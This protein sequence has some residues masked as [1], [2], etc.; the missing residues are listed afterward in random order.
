MDANAPTS[1][2]VVGVA[3]ARVLRPQGLAGLR[4]AVAECVQA[5]LS[6]APLGGGTV[7][8]VGFPP[9]RL[10]AAISMH[11]V[12]GVLEHNP[13][14]FTVSVACGT[15]L[16][17]LEA[18]LLAHGQMLPLDAPFPERAT[19]GGTLAVG[20]IGHRAGRYGTL[21]DLCIGLKAIL[22]TGEEVKSGG[23]V[24]KNVTGYDLTKLHIGALG[25]LGVIATANFRL[26][27][28]PPRQV[29]MVCRFAGRT[30]A[31]EAALEL[32]RSVARFSALAVTTPGVYG[33]P[34]E[35][36][37]AVMVLWEG[38]PR[39]ADR[40]VDMVAAT[41]SRLQGQCEQLEGGASQRLWGSVRDWPLE[42]PSASPWAAVRVRFRPS[43]AEIVLDRLSRTAAE[44]GLQLDGVAHVLAGTAYMKVRWVGQPGEQA[45]RSVVGLLTS[46]ARAGLRMLVLDWAPRSMGP[47]PVWGQDPPGLELMRRIKT[48]FDPKGLIN[49]GRFVGRL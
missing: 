32:A 34:S 33:G 31:F 14:D 6:F 17:E 40:A 48:S 21:R 35:E 26:L 43:E 8:A 7:L 45:E 4:E 47:V 10:D 25:T 39:A 23:M 15:T 11:E 22:G 9:E 16:S 38:S 36:G 42:A 30:Q 13:P 44:H 27:P 19:V 12:R 20:W 46:M 29:S 3:P 41:A 28:L 49:P 24:V 5:G 37:W 18:V 1:V 2:S